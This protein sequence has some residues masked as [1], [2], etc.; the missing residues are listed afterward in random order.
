MR[1]VN[2]E[3]ISEEQFRDY[4]NVRCSGMTNM[5]DV[6]MV[7]RLSDDLDKDLCLCIM[8]NYGNLMEKYP[9]VRNEN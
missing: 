4:E 9:G 8:K 1:I 2:W 6:N 5:L 3:D 7:C